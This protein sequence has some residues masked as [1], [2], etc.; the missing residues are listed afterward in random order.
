[1]SGN[2]NFNLA[3]LIAAGMVVGSLAG[4]MLVHRLPTEPI[5]KLIAFLLVIVGFGIGIHQLIKL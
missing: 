2:L 1:M 3:L 5:R 4:A